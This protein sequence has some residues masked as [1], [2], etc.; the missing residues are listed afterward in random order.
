MVLSLTKHEIKH[1][2]ER[3][4]NEVLNMLQ[5]VKGKRVF[6]GSECW[7]GWG[8]DVKAARRRSDQRC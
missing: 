1:S 6:Q 8:R 7:P 3:L 4:R 5:F 2:V